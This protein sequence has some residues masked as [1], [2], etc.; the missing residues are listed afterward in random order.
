MELDDDDMDEDVPPVEEDDDGEE[1]VVHETFDDLV[2]DYE[3]GDDM[4]E[5][6]EEGDLVLQDDSLAV[7]TKSFFFYFHLCSLLLQ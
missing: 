2:D 1:W 3:G 4:G 5:D 7:S 6:G